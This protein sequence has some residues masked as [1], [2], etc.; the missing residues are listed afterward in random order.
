MSSLSITAMNQRH[1]RLSDA[2]S[3]RRANL[4]FVIGTA[5]LIVTVFTTP[6]SETWMRSLL[7]HWDKVDAM[8]TTLRFGNPARQV[9]LA[10]LGLF[11]LAGIVWPNGRSLRISGLLV[12]GIA[13]LMWCAASYLWTDDAGMSA[14]RIVALGCEVLAGL[15]IARRAAPRQFV[16]IVFACTLTWLAMG[17]LAECTLGTFHPGRPA[18]RFAGIFHPNEMG[19]DCTLVIVS[20]LYLA[21]GYKRTPYWLYA[22]AALSCG[23]LLL[24][25]SRTAVSTLVVL[26]AVFWFATTSLRKQL[27]ATLVAGVAAASLLIALGLGLFNPSVN[28]ITVGRTDVEPSSLTGRLPLWEKLIQDYVSESVLIGHGYGAFWTSDHID[29]LS[30][31]L[32]WAVGGTHSTYVDLLLHVG[33]IGAALCLSAMILAIARSLR[34]ERQQPG[35]GYGLMGMIVASGLTVGL[36]ETTVGLTWSLSFFGIAGVC[37]LIFADDRATGRAPDSFGESGDRRGTVASRVVNGSRARSSRRERRR[38]S[39]A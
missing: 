13:Y 22:I 25:G 27:I 17:L 20:A 5:F 38:L 7:E 9:A 14:R 37:M 18:Y 12:V 31:S 36:F 32:Y 34:L 29:Q 33:V 28:V 21:N 16:W 24:S 6:I 8:A 1:G 39:N 15:A 19:V 10:C 35:N 23:F 26:L 2:V 30:R 3:M 4:P 11:G